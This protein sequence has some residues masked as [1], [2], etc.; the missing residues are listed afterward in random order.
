MN[1]NHS[2]SR[3]FFAEF[4]ATRIKA[5]RVESVGSERPAGR[6]A[7][8]AAGSAAGHGPRSDAESQ[9]DTAARDGRHSLLGGLAEPRRAPGLE[10]G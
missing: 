9:P 8:H 5:W 1:A 10:V 6:S 3:R 4:I 2:F 7:H